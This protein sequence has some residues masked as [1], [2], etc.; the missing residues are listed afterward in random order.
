MSQKDYLRI[1]KIS[2]FNYPKGTARITYED[3]NSSTTVEM[4]FIAW[5]YFMPEVGDQVLVAHLSNGTCPLYRD[6]GIKM[7]FLDHP[8]DIAQNLFAV[9]AIEAVERWEPR[10]IVKEVIFEPDINGKFK[11]KVVIG[12]G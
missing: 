8:L 6:F 9:E 10:V 2:S 11:A 3:R 12:Y 5:E 7:T 4:P 1:G